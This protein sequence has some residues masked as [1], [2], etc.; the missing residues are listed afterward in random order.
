MTSRSDGTHYVLCVK[1]RG[2]KASLEVRKVYRLLEAGKPSSRRLLRVIDES[3][4]DYLYPQGYFVP[5]DVPSAA[6]R[7]FSKASS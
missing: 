4:E 1:N 5:I 6:I 2:Y 7:A 3:G